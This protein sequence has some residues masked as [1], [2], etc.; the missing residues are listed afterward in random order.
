MRTIAPVATLLSCLS[1]MPLAASGASAPGVMPNAFTRVDMPSWPPRQ[2]ALDTRHLALPRFTLLTPALVPITQS[3]IAPLPKAMEAEHLS[4]RG[5]AGSAPTKL[6][7][8]KNLRLD[9]N[10]GP[11]KGLASPKGPIAVTFGHRDGEIFI[12]GLY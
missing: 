9:K 10:L 5:K 4:T 6:R 7:W 11:A 3:H 2:K 8:A 12:G 1:L